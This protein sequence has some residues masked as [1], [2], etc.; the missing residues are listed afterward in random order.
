[1]T[2]LQLIQAFLQLQLQVQGQAL[3]LASLQARVGELEEAD[4]GPPPENGPPVP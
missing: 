1:M 4:P 2:L 3:Q